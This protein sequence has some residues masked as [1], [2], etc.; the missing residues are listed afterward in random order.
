MSNVFA[1]STANTAIEGAIGYDTTNHKLAY[2]NH[3]PAWVDLPIG[4]ASSTS[5]HVVSFADTSGSTLQ[6]SGV[7]SANVV[8]NTG[9]V[10]TANNLALFSGTTGRLVYDGSLPSADVVLNVGGAVVSGDL[11]SFNGTGGRAIQDSG[12]VA[13]NVVTGPASVVSANLAAFSGTTGK[14]LQDSLIS[15]TYSSSTSKILNPNSGSAASITVDVHLMA[16]SNGTFKTVF[17]TVTNTTPATGIVTTSNPA[18]WQGATGVI[19]NQYRPA[20]NTPIT[21]VMFNGTSYLLA[22]MTIGISGGDLTIN[23]AQAAGT[24]NFTIMSGV[25]Y[26]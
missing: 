4:P 8:Q 21:G 5:G 13:A 22:E 19:Q 1:E 11:C 15:I 9:G 6:D 25:Y 20:N 2:G 3:T 23:L 17:L 12:V 18:Q 26:V 16:I 7:A 14:I 24:Y 10:V